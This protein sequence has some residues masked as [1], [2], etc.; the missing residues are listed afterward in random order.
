MDA[1]IKARW[2]E[3]LRS[4]RYKQGKYRLRT[5]DDQFCCLGV[6]CDLV[7][8][9]RWIPAE[10]GGE[11]VY[12]HG[13]SH[14]IGFPALDMLGGGGLSSGTASTLIKLNDAGAS[15]PEIADYIEANL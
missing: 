15:F 6:L 2:L 9:E 8:P 12:A 13:H 4:G 14:F 3:A 10:D 5:H 7:E 1:E 11:P